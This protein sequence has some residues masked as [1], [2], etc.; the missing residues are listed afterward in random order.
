MIDLYDPIHLEQLEQLADRPVLEQRAILFDAFV[1]ERIL[2]ELD[3]ALD[4]R[5]DDLDIPFDAIVRLLDG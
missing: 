3:V 4:D 1:L 5:P 2:G